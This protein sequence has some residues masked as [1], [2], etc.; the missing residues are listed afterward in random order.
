MA[1][2]NTAALARPIHIQ[3]GFAARTDVSRNFGLEVVRAAAISSVLVGHFTAVTAI[4]MGT[5]AP[6][7]IALMGGSG[8]ELFFALSGFLI[9]GLLLDIAKP[10]LRACAPFQDRGRRRT[11]P[12]RPS[13]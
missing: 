3:K 10:S 6:T 2:E 13:M 5:R 1:L 7:F 4:L 12:L 9:G 11:Q 8:V